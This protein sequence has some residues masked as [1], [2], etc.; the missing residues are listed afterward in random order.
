MVKVN[1]YG[2]PMKVHITLLTYFPS[3]KLAVPQELQR[4]WRWFLM[5]MASESGC[6]SLFR[7]KIAGGAFDGTI[8]VTGKNVKRNNDACYLSY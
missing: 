3:H 4:L 6:P 1:I 5:G 8:H 2:N 7:T